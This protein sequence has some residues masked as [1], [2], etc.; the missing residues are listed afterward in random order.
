MGV[1]FLCSQTFGGFLQHIIWQTFVEP[2]VEGRRFDL[3]EW[4]F[5]LNLHVVLLLVKEVHWKKD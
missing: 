1:L 2:G 3:S 5:D 4:S